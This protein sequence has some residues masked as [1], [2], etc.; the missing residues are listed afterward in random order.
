MFS[1]S[2]EADGFDGVRN[3]VQWWFEAWGDGP[4]PNWKI[5]GEVGRPPTPEELVRADY[6]VFGFNTRSGV[7]YKTRVGGLDLRL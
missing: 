7:S 3:G 4:K 5:R 1:T 2:R 6:I